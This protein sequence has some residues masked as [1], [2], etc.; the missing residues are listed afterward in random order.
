MPVVEMPDCLFIFGFLPVLHVG[1]FPLSAV[2]HESDNSADLLVIPLAHHGR[3]AEFAVAAAHREADEALAAL[4][5]LV[6]RHALE[7]PLEALLDVG[8]QAVEHRRDVALPGRGH[9]RGPGLLG[10]GVARIGARGQPAADAALTEEGLRCRPYVRRRVLSAGGREDRRGEIPRRIMPGEETEH[11][12]G[13][14]LEHGGETA[15]DLAP[16]PRP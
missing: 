13:P 1:Y 12:P 16:R 11:L 2:L 9:E 8:H 14:E 5:Q 15:P 10:V 7:E 6:A 3:F 4:A